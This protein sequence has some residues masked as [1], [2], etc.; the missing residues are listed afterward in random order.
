MYLPGAKP[1]LNAKGKPLKPEP[2]CRGKLEPEE[3]TYVT[4]L[5]G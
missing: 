1:N 5:A 2:K 4:R 3:A